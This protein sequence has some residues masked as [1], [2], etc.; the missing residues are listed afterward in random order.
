[1][2]KFEKVVRLYPPSDDDLRNKQD[3][4]AP[5]VYPTVL[6]LMPLAKRCPELAKI[7]VCKSNDQEDH[8][9]K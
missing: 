8:K 4:S 3:S 1:M 9:R 2:E 7:I 5:K 6:D